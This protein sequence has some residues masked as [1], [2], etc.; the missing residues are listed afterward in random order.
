M[1]YAPASDGHRLVTSKGA[2]IWYRHVEGDGPTCVFLHGLGGNSVPLRRLAAPLEEHGRAT[3]LVDLRGHG[4]SDA[5]ET[6]TYSLE[7]YALDVLEVLNSLG[8][9]RIDMVGHCMGGMVVLKIREL[10]PEVLGNVVLISTSSRTRRD[11]RSRTI[12]TAARFADSVLSTVA[13]RFY[14]KR[15]MAHSDP[16]V[17]PRHPDIYLPRLRADVANT[18]LRVIARSLSGILAADMRAAAASSDH[19]VLVIHGCR[20]VIVPVAAARETHALIEGSRLV[21]KESDGHVSHVLGDVESLS[22]DVCVFLGVA[23][24]EQRD[25]AWDG[26]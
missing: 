14:R 13:P 25:T 12:G 7:E 26:G 23:T 9:E 18:S 19:R 21:L 4:L 16:C 15:V 1:M 10:R 17:F 3:L 24:D 20:D 6:A 5:P 8:I 2:K 11:A 22:G